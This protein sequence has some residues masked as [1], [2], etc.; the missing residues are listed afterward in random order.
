M[1]YVNNSA[2]KI[3][4]QYSRGPFRNTDSIMTAIVNAAEVMTDPDKIIFYQ[5]ILEKNTEVINL[6][7]PVCTAPPERC[8][9]H[10]SLEEIQYVLSNA[11]IDLGVKLNEDTLT[12]EEKDKYADAIDKLM[13]EIQTLKDGQEIIYTDLKQEL[14]EIKEYMYLGK[15]KFTYMLTG[16]MFEMVASGVVSETISKG[17]LNELKNLSGFI[18]DHLLK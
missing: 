15:K 1:S 8:S 7:T 9:F 5:K 18:S 16:K 14:E 12:Y 13:T 10:L 2:N 3:I 11:L 6:H 17:F 4:Q